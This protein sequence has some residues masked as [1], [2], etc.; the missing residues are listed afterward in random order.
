[1]VALATTARSTGSPTRPSRAARGRA[2]ANICAPAAP[3][4]RSWGRR[5]RRVA[6]GGFRSLPLP[7]PLPLTEPEE[8]L[9]MASATAATAAVMARGLAV[10]EEPVEAREAVLGLVLRRWLP[11]GLRPA[12]EYRRPAPTPALSSVSLRMVRPG[13]ATGVRAS[14]GPLMGVVLPLVGVRALW[15]DLARGVLGAGDRP[16][17][18]TACGDLDLR[19][20]EGDLE[21]RFRAGDLDLVWLGDRPLVPLGV[22]ARLRLRGVAS[23]TGPGTRPARSNGAPEEAEASDTVDCPDE[24]EEEL[25]E[26]EEAEEAEEPEGP[27]HLPDLGDPAPTARLLLLL[28]LPAPTPAPSMDGRDRPAAGTPVGAVPLA[29]TLAVAAGAGVGVLGTAPLPPLPPLPCCDKRWSVRAPLAVGDWSP[30]PWGATSTTTCGPG[31]VGAAAV[32]VVGVRPGP[33]LPTTTSS[34]EALPLKAR[35]DLGVVGPLL[36][37]FPA[38]VGVAWCGEVLSLLLALP[39]VWLPRRAC[40]ARA[41]SLL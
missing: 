25:E 36:L 17:P 29:V 8:A 37:R 28:L 6:A 7:L 22:L 41:L 31:P 10:R 32:R 23:T 35:L 2:T 34:A 39:G 40:L 5:L 13:R 16:C 30:L 19:P 14:G 38:E 24:E 20:V 26:A 15:G 3:W 18:R 9:V 27:S 1:M 12:P 21:G 33:A 11:V 4:V